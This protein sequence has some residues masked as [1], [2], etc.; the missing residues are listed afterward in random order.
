MEHTTTLQQEY[1]DEGYVLLENVISKDLLS[2]LAMTLYASLAQGR[3]DWHECSLDELIL[4]RE[5]EDHSLVYNAATSLG[6]AAASYRLLGKSELLT[7]ASEALGADIEQLHVLPLYLII[8]LP[9]DGRFDYEWHQDGAYYPWCRDL[10]TIWFPV[11]HRS[12]QQNGT[13]SVVPASHKD[14]LREANTHFRHGNFR[15]IISPVRGGESDNEIPL[16]VN[17]GGCCLSH[18]ALVHRSVANASKSPR[19]SGILRLVDMS[20]QK[21]YQRHLFFCMGNSR[22]TVSEPDKLSIANS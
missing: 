13:M 15:Q 16:D 8:Q 9:G 14:G 10:A 4:K 21:D 6:S 7:H 1:L 20:R 22:K 17:L 12:S 5:A 18:G 2:G 3:Q 19:V 11:T